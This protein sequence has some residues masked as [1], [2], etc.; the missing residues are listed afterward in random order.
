MTMNST[1]FDYTETKP[2]LSAMG[3]VVESIGV[4]TDTTASELFISVPLIGSNFRSIPEFSMK[5]VSD[6]AFA[7]YNCRR[8]VLKRTANCTVDGKSVSAAPLLQDCSPY[9]CSGCKLGISPTDMVYKLKVWF[10]NRRS[11]ER[12]LKHLCNY[13]RHYEQ[14]GLLPP[15][16]QFTTGEGGSSSEAAS[17]SQYLNGIEGQFDEEDE[18][19]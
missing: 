7:T 17:F 5:T 3:H 9:R 16:I 12:R 18:E 2:P 19:D 10:Q 15:P 11:K 8:S 1:D 6:A 14:R 13:L 4:D